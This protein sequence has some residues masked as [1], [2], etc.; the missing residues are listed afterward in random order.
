MKI[1]ALV[2]LLFLAIPLMGF[3]CVNDAFTISLNLAP[4]NGTYA[5]N[6]GPTTFGGS[7][8]INT[9]TMYDQGYTLTGASV[10]DITVATAGPNLGTCTGAVTINTIPLLTYSGPWTG[11]NTPQ[12]LLTSRYITRDA[13][14]IAELISCVVNK[15][16]AV[17]ATAGNVTTSPAAAGT[18][19]LTISAHVQAWGQ[20]S[21]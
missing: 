20:L 21:K 8:S 14:G 4:F 16:I 2:L 17:F 7:F 9:T 19:T 1:R 18:N 11:F 13:R 12:S 10:Y 3:N 5:L 15:R 6:P